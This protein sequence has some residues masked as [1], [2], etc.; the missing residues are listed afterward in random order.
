MIET[1]AKKRGG[2]GG[3]KKKENLREKN[4]K[5][6][7]GY[8]VTTVSFLLCLVK[9]TSSNHIPNSLSLLLSLSYCV[10]YKNTIQNP[11]S[12]AACTVRDPQS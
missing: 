7:S 1:S 6:D 3:R 9:V 11:W 2:S 10:K 12:L 4:S 8:L 5:R